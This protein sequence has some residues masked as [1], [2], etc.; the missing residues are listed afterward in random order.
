MLLRDTFHLF[1]PF[2]SRRL[3]NLCD[4]LM[5]V[6]FPRCAGKNNV[7][8]NVATA[9]YSESDIPALPE[10]EDQKGAWDIRLG[11]NPDAAIFD[12]SRENR[13]TFLAAHQT[14][15][16]ADTGRKGGPGLH[17]PRL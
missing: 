13:Q 5:M 3:N 7:L 10:Q 15:D 4:L 2:F 17:R 16:F 1:K 14:H 9:I 12:F 6:V 11:I 8:T